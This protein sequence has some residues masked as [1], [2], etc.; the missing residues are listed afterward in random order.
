[1]VIWFYRLCC[2]DRPL[3]IA[4]EALFDLAARRDEESGGSAIA[5]IALLCCSFEGDRPQSYSIV[6]TAAEQVPSVVS[7]ERADVA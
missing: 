1:M 7:L 2:G 3:T 4:V 6:L 5:S